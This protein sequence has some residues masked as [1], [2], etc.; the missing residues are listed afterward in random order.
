ME[1]IELNTLKEQ[2]IQDLLG[3]MEVL[4]GSI[5]VTPE[6]LKAAAEAPETHLFAAVED[7]R[8]IGT[9]SLCITRHPLGLKGGIEDVVV[10]PEARG[11]HIGRKL[12]EHIIEYARGLAPIELHL[13]S[14][15]SREKAN[16]LYQT[17]GFRQHETNVY[18][19]SL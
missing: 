6:I 16:L 17:L 13:T 5:K 2:D 15:P 11:R 19:M 9:A 10:S 8:I 14:R 1:I 7:G 4:D 18:K 3:L 12:M